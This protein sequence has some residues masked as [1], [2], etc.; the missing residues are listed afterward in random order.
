MVTLVLIGI[1]I[2]L[3]I[4][5]T[6]KKNLVSLSGLLAFAGVAFLLSSNPSKVST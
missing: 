2:Y 6:D 4:D 1:I 3:S 5:L